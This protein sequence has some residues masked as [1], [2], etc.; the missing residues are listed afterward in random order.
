MNRDLG[1][2]NVYV[3]NDFI[4]VCQLWEVL[5]AILPNDYMWI[6]IGNFNMVETQIDK[7]STC[8]KMLLGTKGLDWEVFKTTLDV[9]ELVNLNGNLKFSWDDHQNGIKLIL[10][11]L[12]H[13]Y[14]ASTHSLQNELKINIIWG[15]V[16]GRS[17]DHLV[18]NGV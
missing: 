18:Y 17:N 1:I 16:D 3:P 6:L 4:E 5:K 10:T 2:H 9:N 7:S 12:D 15:D 14:V 13:A 8:G 11:K